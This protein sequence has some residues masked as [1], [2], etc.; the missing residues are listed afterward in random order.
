MTTT[1]NA[2]PTD[3]G[4]CGTAAGRQ[5]HRR[6]GRPLVTAEDREAAKA[7]PR[8]TSGILVGRQTWHE[9]VA[10][11]VKTG[12]GTLCAACWGWRDDPR[13][14]VLGGPVVGR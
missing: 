4:V 13:H 11:P 10:M 2:G 8:L 12:V 1:T 9:F 5:R 3:T 14:P 6:R 7:A